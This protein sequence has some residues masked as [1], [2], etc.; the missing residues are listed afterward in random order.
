MRKIR[1]ATSVLAK[2][3]LLDDINSAVTPILADYLGEHP[4]D[5]LT[6]LNLVSVFRK[7]ER[8]GD[9]YYEYG[10][11]DNLF[12]KCKSIETS[13]KY[14]RTLYLICPKKYI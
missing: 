7:L 5:R 3:N 1:L 13:G 12:C 8:A 11:R 4:D 10:R 9:A 2:D 14:R 6:C